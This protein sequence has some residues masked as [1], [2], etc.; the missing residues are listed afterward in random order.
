MAE[1]QI[2]DVLST[3]AEPGE[4]PPPSLWSKIDSGLT[5]VLGPV[6]R[7][8]EGAGGVLAGINRPVPLK[9]ISVTSKDPLDRILAGESADDAYGREPGRVESFLASPDGQKL[10]F[11]S[12]LVGPAAPKLARPKGRSA[13]Q[14]GRGSEEAMIEGAKAGAHLKRRE[15]GK[16]VGAPEWVD[17]PQ[18]LSALRKELDR[19]IDEGEAG[20]GWYD[21]GRSAVKEITGNDKRANKITANTLGI[22]SSQATPD[23]NLG[24][25]VQGLGTRAITGEVPPVVRFGHMSKAIEDQI[26]TGGES[27]KGLGAKTGVFADT[28]NPDMEGKFHG[29]TNDIWHARAFK[30]DDKWSGTP[31]K[32][33]HAF[34]DGETALAMLRAN[35]AREAE[36]A[37]PLTMPNVQERIWAGKQIEALIRDGYTPDEAAQKALGRSFQDYLDKYTLSATHEF[38]PGGPTGHLAGM[39]SLDKA[40]GSFYDSPATTWATAPGGRD[41]I[42]SSM[43]LM[44]VRPTAKMQG[45]WEDP[46]KGFQTN[47]GEVA[48]PLVPLGEGE[49]KSRAMTPVA[50]SA[51]EGAEALRAYLS[52]QSGAA[53]HRLSPGQAGASRAVDVPMAR[54]LTE[55]EMIELSGAMKERGYNVSDRGK[56]VTVMDFGFGK[57][58]EDLRGDFPGIRSD[59]RRILPESGE[60]SRRV[61]EGTYQ[62]M[63]FSTPGSGTATRQML[64]K[65]DAVPEFGRRAMGQSPMVMERAAAMRDRDA[66]LSQEYKLP[67]REDIQLARDIFSKEGLQGLREALARGAVLPSAAVAIVGTMALK[68][69]EMPQ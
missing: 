49:G 53:T 18:K 63:D 34:M 23:Q 68:G 46:V 21:A 39:S 17:S 27:R 20:Q 54:G 36:G 7:A 16:Y 57:G 44:P 5:S 15:E 48:R 29:S 8:L 50:R 62:D 28:L 31:T 67:L 26:K 40:L 69:E 11:L 38:M 6:N 47:R 19:L 45:A 43:D 52:A 4:D 9:P 13:V 59:V 25:T 1:R 30:K 32:Q 24:Y 2:D 14:S 66:L 60:P 37:T 58:P 3:Y 12:Q 41:A 61:F 42:Y 64:E 10:M 35:A 51:V 65:M 55:A 56:G 22:T 33:E